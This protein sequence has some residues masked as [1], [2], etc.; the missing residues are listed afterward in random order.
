MDANPEKEKNKMPKN[1]RMVTLIAFIT[2]AVGAYYFWWWSSW[3]I[4][5]H[6]VDAV[7]IGRIASALFPILS[8]VLLLMFSDLARKFFIFTNLLFAFNILSNEIALPLV[9][10]SGDFAHLKKDVF[11]IAIFTIIFCILSVLYLIR[12]DV[13]KEFKWAGTNRLF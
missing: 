3:A 10:S 2:I 9:W 7:T 5:R 12:S 11:A 13:R 4:K 8:G 6:F 1:R